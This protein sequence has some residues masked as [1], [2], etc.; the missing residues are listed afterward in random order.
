MLI[1]LSTGLIIF[2]SIVFLCLLILFLRKSILK[3][4]YLIKVFFYQI[5][6]INLTKIISFNFKKIVKAEPSLNMTAINE[7]INI[8]NEI[9]KS[10]TLKRHSSI[11]SDSYL[12]NKED[13]LLKSNQENHKTLDSE[14]KPKDNLFFGTIQCLTSDINWE[15]SNE[16]I[17][18]NESKS[19]DDV[20]LNNGKSSQ[21]FNLNADNEHLSKSMLKRPEISRHGDDA[22]EEFFRLYDC[23]LEIGNTILGDEDK[24]EKGASFL[25]LFDKKTK[26]SYSSDHQRSENHKLNILLGSKNE[27]TY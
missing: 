19:D 14:N 21:V 10:F 12:E 13:Q 9:R 26:V 27:I 2:V 1:W 6:F 20:K 22:N 3:K 4:K 23:Y 8:E 17:I 16:I 18:Q 5:T 11:A 15:V 25:L 7:E 24:L